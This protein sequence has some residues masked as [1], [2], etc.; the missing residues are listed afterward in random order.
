MSASVLY[1]LKSNF[2]ASNLKA[3]AVGATG[4][5]GGWSASDSCI[6]HVVNSF[7]IVM[8]MLSFMH[9]FDTTMAQ[10]KARLHARASA[11]ETI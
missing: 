7:Q 11:A 3:A 5:G 9:L 4:G 8:I 1:L 10:H 6:P 2:S